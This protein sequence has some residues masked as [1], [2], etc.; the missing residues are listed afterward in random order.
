MTPA[1]KRLLELAA[2]GARIP[3]TWG[4][5]GV[6]GGVPFHYGIMIQWNPLTDDADEARL[7]AA[8]GLDV[9]WYP[10]FVDVR[11]M[12]WGDTDTFAREAFRDHGNDKQSARRRAGVL[13]AAAIGNAMP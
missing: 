9:T 5:G 6:E 1:D 12:D 11:R 13:V 3:I 7:E 8:L 10:E 4:N 2:K